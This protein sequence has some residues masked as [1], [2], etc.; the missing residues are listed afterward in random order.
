MFGNILFTELSYTGIIRLMNTKMHIKIFFVV[1]IAIIVVFTIEHAYAPGRESVGQIA[2]KVSYSC[3]GG[4]SIAA[5][6]YQGKT[7]LP[8]SPDQ[9]PVP[10]GRVVL[11]LSDGRRMSINQTISAD[12]NRYANNDE[13]F[14]FWGKG[15]GALVLENNQE[16]SYIGCISVAPEQAGQGLARIYSNSGY[17]FSIRLPGEVSSSSTNDSDNFKVDESY[18]YQAFGSK[19]IINGIKFAIPFSYA[20]GT[21]L[22]SDSYV[23]VEEIPQALECNASLFTVQG[24]ASKMISDDGKDYS[25]ATSSDAGAGNRYEETIYSLPGTNP[26]VA[27][28][29]FLHYTVIE[30][31]PEGTVVQ[32]DKK[33][34]LN[35]FDQI[36]RTLV[37]NP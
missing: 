7:V 32:F 14:V 8:S 6:Y 30:N 22:S 4:K 37:L 35:Q 26:C 29:Y 25:L 17:G 13:S 33:K 31:Y 3:N 9:P 28:R 23:S 11:V 34:I 24:S 20:S 2:N 12:G 36:R 16:R 18:K 10:G 27:I 19:K 1:V 21:N 15:N 5:E